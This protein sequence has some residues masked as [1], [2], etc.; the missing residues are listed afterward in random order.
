MKGNSMN[1]TSSHRSPEAGAL[2]PSQRSLGKDDQV[3]LDRLVLERGTRPAAVLLGV[4]SVVVDSLVHGGRA[5][6]STV[7]VVSTA[8]E[9]LSA[10]GGAQ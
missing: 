3:R 2:R 9:T 5:K 10:K 7:T 8:L 4:S 1:H 6:E